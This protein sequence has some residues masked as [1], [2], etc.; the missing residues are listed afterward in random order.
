M[1][2]I[3]C[4]ILYRS[5]LSALDKDY[6]IIFHLAA[7]IGV[8]NV[9]ERPY[10]VLK[11]NVAMIINLLEFAKMQKR[12]RRF[13]F[14]STSEVYTGTLKH[15]DLPI[16]TSEETPL[17]LTDLSHPRT[18]YMLSKIYGEA[19]C[20]QSKIPFIILRPHNV[21]GPRM[22]MSHVIPELLK[23]AYTAK[24]GDKLEVFS[25]DHRRTFCYIEDAV[26]M[27][28]LAIEA[29]DCE[30]ETLNIGSQSPEITMGDLAAIIID[31]V[32]KDLM[33]K[34]LPAT[35]GSPVR[36]CPDMNK[37]A[38]LTRYAPK[39]TLQKGIQKTYAWYNRLQIFN[40]NSVSSR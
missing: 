30:N 17:G 3:E 8:S 10:E 16:P 7:I 4:D 11:D 29:H 13:V 25:V 6:D 39:V 9:L 38:R 12:L 2:F 34:A 23:K 26:N 40:G 32:G 21:Y 5:S 36:R 24:D 28:R 33:Q 14:A 15:F 1:D 19:L 35:P 27:I 22:G 20:H 31:V 37:T 18:S